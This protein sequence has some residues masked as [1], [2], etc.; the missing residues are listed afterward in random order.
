MS[1]EHSITNDEARAEIMELRRETMELRLALER[2]RRHR[3]SL[4]EHIAILQ[5]QQNTYSRKHDHDR[6]VAFYC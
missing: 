6:L 3:I 5:Q 1:P 4:E 2:E